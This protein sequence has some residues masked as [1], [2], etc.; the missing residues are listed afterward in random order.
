MHKTAKMFSF[1]DLSQVEIR[2][3]KLGTVNYSLH[4]NVCHVKHCSNCKLKRE[5]STVE[6]AY[7]GRGAS[8]HSHRTDLGGRSHSVD[9][10][11]K[12][13]NTTLQQNGAGS[14]L[15]ACLYPRST[16]V[17]APWQCGT[18][19]VQ[20]ACKV[21]ESQKNKCM[22]TLLKHGDGP[23]SS[24]WF[25]VVG[26]LGCA[27]MWARRRLDTTALVP[28]PFSKP[29]LKASRVLTAPLPTADCPGHGVT[30]IQ[31]RQLGSLPSIYNRAK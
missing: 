1:P 25:Q 9:W 4:L 11:T 27:H 7:A 22:M 2:A 5:V 17:A 21:S 31:W 24:C 30:Y 23:S 8:A 15:G 6:T 13:T 26:Q 3:Q 19:R 29:L 18:S 28:R 12:K 20:S 14:S 16:P 10:H